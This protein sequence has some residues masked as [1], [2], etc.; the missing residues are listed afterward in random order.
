MPEK[1]KKSRGGGASS[2]DEIF[3]VSVVGVGAA[4]T[5]FVRVP[6]AGEKLKSWGIQAAWVIGVI[7]ISAL[8]AAFVFSVVRNVLAP[9]G[10]DLSEDEAVEDEFSE[11]QDEEA[12]DELETDSDGDD[13]SYLEYGIGGEAGKRETTD[14][15]FIRAIE[16]AV[17]AAQLEAEQ[18]AAQAG[19]NPSPVRIH[20]SDLMEVLTEAG[21]WTGT[22][23][24]GLRQ[25]I[26]TTHIPPRDTVFPVTDKVKVV[27]TVQK[28]GESKRKE[29]VR[30]GLKYEDVC[31]ALGRTPRLPP[32]L[33]PDLTRNS[34]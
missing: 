33:V 30:A 18:K 28:Q 2:K 10:N 13:P 9:P 34:L 16:Y 14:A 25:K 12:G 22:E 24:T 27:K 19:K 31:E 11:E 4:V 5:F 21:I 29:F 7:L 17:A 1:N 3:I 6:D 8:A 26:E 15:E 23:V 20:L 32:H